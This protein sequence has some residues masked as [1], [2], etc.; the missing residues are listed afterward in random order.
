MEELAAELP[1]F[2]TVSVT[3]NDSLLR[4]DSGRFVTNVTSKS[5]PST[6]TRFVEVKQLLVSS[7]SFTLLPPSAQTIR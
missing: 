3:E 2:F 6:S 1:L 7:L 4:I 5:G